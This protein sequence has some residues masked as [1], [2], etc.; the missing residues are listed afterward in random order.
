M[1]CQSQVCFISL[2]GNFFRDLVGTG[3]NCAVCEII[4]DIVRD[5]MTNPDFDNWIEPFVV[6]MCAALKI[7]DNF[8]CQ[9]F[10]S[11]NKVKLSWVILGYFK[12]NFC[13]F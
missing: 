7:E 3:Q 4:V 9:G 6:F 10:V 12:S 11:A 13:K 1:P 5:S 8:V 2:W